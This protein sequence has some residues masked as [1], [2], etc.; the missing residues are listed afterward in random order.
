MA[1]VE[2]SLAVVLIEVKK[3]KILTV[4]VMVV[5][6]IIKLMEAKEKKILTVMVMVVAR[7][8]KQAMM[9]K[10]MHLCGPWAVRDDYKTLD[11]DGRVPK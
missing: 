1:M 11:E 10:L 6:R 9:R 8:V 5:A 7:F 2:E 4:L 3:T